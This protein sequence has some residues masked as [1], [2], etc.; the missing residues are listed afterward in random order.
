MYATVVNVLIVIVTVYLVYLTS[1]TLLSLYNYD[2]VLPRVDW[3][4]HTLRKINSV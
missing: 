2:I 3:V 4:L 1:P